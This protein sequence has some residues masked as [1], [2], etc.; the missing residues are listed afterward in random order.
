[1]VTD[2]GTFALSEQG[3]GVWA[4][5]APGGRTGLRYQFRIKGDE[6]LYADP[7]SRFQP[8]GPLGASEAV[9]TDFHWTDRGFRPPRFPVIYELHL[10]TFSPEGTWEGAR[11][12]LRFLKELGVDMVEIMPV[13]EFA[14]RH[15]WGYDGVQWY[16]PFHGYGRPD[17][18]RRF[19]NDAHAQGIAVILDVVYNHFGPAGNMLGSLVPEHA[20]KE[21][22]EWGQALNFDG[23]G[24]AF[25]R[26]LVVDNAAYWIDEFHLDGLRLDATQAISD[27]SATHVIAEL[28]AAARAAAPDKELFLVAEN[29]PQNTRL[30]RSPGTGGYGLDALWND[31]FHHSAM[32]ALCG[33]REAYYADYEG[34][35]RELLSC[36]KHGYLY[37]GQYYPW[38]EKRRGASTRGLAPRSM[39]A[40][41]ENHDQVA[42]YGLGGRLWQ[43]SQ[44]G[45]YRALTGLLLLAPWTPM[46]FQGQEWRTRSPFTFFADHTREL[47]EAVAK[48]RAEFLSQ[49]PR[50]ADPK[51]RAQFPNPVAEET[52]RMCRLDWDERKEPAAAAS[53]DMH[54]DLLRLRREDATLTGARQ[55][56]LGFDGAWLAEGLFLVRFFGGSQDGADDRL[57]VVSLRADWRQPGVTEP[58]CAPPPG[59]SWKLVWS[60]EDVV[61]GGQGTRTLPE[62]EGI[63]FAGHAAELFAA[64]PVG[65]PRPPRPSSDEPSGPSGEGDIEQELGLRG[66]AVTQKRREP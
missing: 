32:V 18:M 19:V 31:D 51:A 64:V 2:I 59:R 21:A 25:M 44:P 8:D 36:V 39:V 26:S 56:H 7:A 24:A 35:A 50:Y 10:G 1:M 28:T 65:T 57:L 12:R 34:S 22:G 61:Y 49:F 62:E 63:F 48:G 40:F 15:G 37:Q 60:S 43:R 5:W 27:T 14:G 33:H 16:A 58:L 55:G 30:A 9:A 20:S 29:E 3:Q 52:F 54:R 17:D 11:S 38:Q 6:H 53:L 45:D 42:N 4:G 13:N 23:E 66:S 41:L 47:N 46:L